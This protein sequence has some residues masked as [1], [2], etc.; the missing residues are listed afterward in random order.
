MCTEIML[1]SEKK[2]KQIC[3]VCMLNM[4]TTLSAVCMQDDECK[5]FLVWMHN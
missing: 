4:V 5:A 3:R 1:Y 2:T